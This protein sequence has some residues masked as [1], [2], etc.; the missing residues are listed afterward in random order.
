MTERRGSRNTTE[1]KHIMVHVCFCFWSVC[2][3]G[4]L[5]QQLEHLADNYSDHRYI[6]NDT[7]HPKTNTPLSSENLRFIYSFILFCVDVVR[8]NESDCG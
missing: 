2:T 6:L 1:K 4:E 8:T 5:K 7:A 3:R